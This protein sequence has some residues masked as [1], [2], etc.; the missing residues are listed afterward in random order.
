[1]ILVDSAI[2]RRGE[3]AKLV[4]R[5]RRGPSQATPVREVLHLDKKPAQAEIGPEKGLAPPPV[6]AGDGNQKLILLGGALYELH[7]ENEYRPVP[8]S[9][10]S[11]FGIT[12]AKRAGVFKSDSALFFGRLLVDSRNNSLKQTVTKEMACV[13][14]QQLAKP[15]DRLKHPEPGSSP[16]VPA[17]PF[18]QFPTIP[19]TG[20]GEFWLVL[21]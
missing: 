4:A 8:G 6:A 21:Q 19:D 18:N 11:N 5:I 9:L 7:P 2:E 13:V 17:I 14:N 3:R 10:G 15:C 16:V 1:M 20:F 12:T